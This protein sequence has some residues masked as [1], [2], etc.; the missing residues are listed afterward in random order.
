MSQQLA[1]VGTLFLHEARSDYTVVATRDGSRVLRG[2]LELKETAAG[3]RP[4]KFRVIRD[5]EDHPRQ[6]DEFVELARAADRIRISEQTAPE[7]RE[8]LEA[9][10]ADYQLES[11]R[12]SVV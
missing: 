10:L 11:D 7:N 9:M 8:R 3:P 4:G 12:K 1:E 6:P 5:G 2:R